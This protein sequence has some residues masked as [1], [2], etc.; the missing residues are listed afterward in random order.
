MRDARAASWRREGLLDG[1]NGRLTSPLA[2]TSVSPLA[3]M[4]DM[5]G[6]R[7]HGPVPYSR[8]E[9]RQ[10]CSRSVRAAAGETAAA[11]ASAAAAAARSEEVGAMPRASSSSAPW[12]PA[13]A[14][15]R[16]SA[17][18]APRRGGEIR[19]ILGTSPRW[20]CTAHR[21]TCHSQIHQIHQIHQIPFILLPLL[22]HAAPLQQNPSRRRIPRPPSRSSIRHFPK[23][24]RPRPRLAPAR[25]CLALSVSVALC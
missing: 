7:G 6:P 18:R 3:D 1:S 17:W 15:G 19:G 25:A 10:M 20:E 21:S 16:S 5:A 12:R 2:G 8:I 11:A 4:A 22:L 9:T 23:S 24:P 14:W 13:A